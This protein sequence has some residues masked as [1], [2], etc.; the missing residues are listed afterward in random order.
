MNLEGS[1]RSSDE[2]TSLKVTILPIVPVMPIVSMLRDRSIGVSPLAP[3]EPPE[4]PISSR[5]RRWGG[6]RSAFSGQRSARKTL[7]GVGWWVKIAVGL[8]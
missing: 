5:N 2:Q 1:H 4:M 3:P 7:N 6:E 8:V